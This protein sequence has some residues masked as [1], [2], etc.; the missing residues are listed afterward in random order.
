MGVGISYMGTKKNL[1]P[2]VA[3]VIAKAQ[4]GILLDAFAG[5][6]SVAEEVGTSRQIWTNDSQIFA[7]ETGKALFASY[8]EPPDPLWIADLHSEIFQREKGRLEA[9][10]SSSLK[11]EKSLLASES[12]ECFAVSAVRY[13]RTYMRETSRLKRPRY[14]L[15][16]HR[17]SRLYD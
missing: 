13:K 2:T 15:V 11:A 16:R 7:A 17:T 14:I 3:Q 9:L 6:C 5:M 10:F 1:A 12:F 8:D 4:P